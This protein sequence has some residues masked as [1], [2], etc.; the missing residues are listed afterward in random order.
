MSQRPRL[1]GDGLL[2][3]PGSLTADAE[4]H[5]L[6]RLSDELVD[7]FE[8]TSERVLLTEAFARLDLDDG[9]RVVDWCA[10]H[11]VLDLADFIGAPSSLPDVDW[12][13][14]APGDESFDSL[15]AIAAEQRNIAWHLATLV[16]LSDRRRTRD[17]D[18]TFGQLVLDV[19]SEGAGLI[20]GGPDAGVWPGIRPP[21]LDG[22]QELT[23]D[24]RRAVEETER[25]VRAATAD[26]PVVRISARGWRPHWVA[27]GSTAMGL[28][29]TPEEKA[30]VLGTT[31]QLTVALERLLL[32][33]YVERAVER[34]FTITS[35][36]QEIGGETRE[37]LVPRDERAWRSVLAP[38]YLQL[39]EAL[40][41]VTEGEPGA[42]ICRE[43]GRAFVVLDA[44]R[45]FF[46]NERERTR[47]AQ[48][49]RRRRLRDEGAG[50]EEP[51]A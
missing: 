36:I 23:P 18:P 15:E 12:L 26:W 40:R 2:R 14:G 19:A 3:L 24:E 1:A 33:P 49:E 38:I 47:F 13:S 20:V 27:R 22:P 6:G 25:R 39:F 5:L 48:R 21:E 9:A 10:R 50:E 42:A 32:A 34:R 31:W 43:C 30:R 8:W 41:R 29:A 35:E 37:V 7:P 28:P 51:E 45:R 46:C 11:G 4:G 17:W 44:R 16:R